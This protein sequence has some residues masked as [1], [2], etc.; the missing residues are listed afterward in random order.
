MPGAPSSAGTTRPESSASAGSWAPVAAACAL[1]AA[2]AA[3]LSPVSS[4][5]GNPS[6]PADTTATSNGATSSSISRTFPGLWLAIT[7]RPP[8]GSL[9]GN[10]PGRAPAGGSRERRALQGDQLVDAV[11]RQAQQLE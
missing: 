10:L 11:A 9:G 1:S 8:R 4:G 7:S 5:S 2:L 6:V 3:K